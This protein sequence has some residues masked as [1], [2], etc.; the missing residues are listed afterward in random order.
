MRRILKQMGWTLVAGEYPGG[1]NHE[2]YPLNVL[3]PEVA[4]DGSPDPRRHSKGE[5][6]PD[7]VALKGRNLLLAEAK[8]AYSASDATKLLELTGP[9]LGDLH[10]ALAKFADER[11]SVD[12][13]PIDSLVL[14]PTLV[15]V[16]G[17]PA[18]P[19]L[20]GFSYLRVQDHFNAFF[21]GTLADGSS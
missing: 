3:D 6:I 11:P 17:K 7:L 12:L 1:S 19:P 5:L 20:P 10:R 8:V 14:H 21:E 4:R 13:L 18:P 2:L 15:F 9:R 16:T